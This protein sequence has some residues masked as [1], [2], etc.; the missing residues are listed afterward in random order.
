MDSSVQRMAD[1][2]RTAV[3]MEADGYSFY[4]MAARSTT[5]PKGQEV[6]RT[7]ADEELGHMEFLKTQY[8][9]VMETGGIDVDA[10]LGPRKAL[11]GENPIFSDAINGRIKDAQIEVSALS[12]G[13]QL[14]LN[15][16]SFYTKQA[17]EETD[18]I[19]RK[20]YKELAEWE[21]GH[22]HALLRQQ[23][24]LKEDYWV[25]GGFAPF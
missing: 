21:S 1:G 15:S 10:R 17:G 13:I 6:F 23:D 14:E 16:I 2:F 25:S 11:A 5:D 22:Y 4:L 3:Q 24:S 9:S 20:F 7:L 8:K 19:V 18:P 12:I